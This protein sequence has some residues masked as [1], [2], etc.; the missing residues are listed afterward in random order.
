MFYLLD[1][2]FDILYG[3]LSLF[4]FIVFQ[5]RVSLHYWKLPKGF[6][7][8]NSINAAEAEIFF[9]HNDEYHHTP[10]IRNMQVQ[11]SLKFAIF[12]KFLKFVKIRKKNWRVGVASSGIL[13]WITYNSKLNVGK[14]WNFL[15][16]Y[17][18]IE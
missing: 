3:R 11:N 6:Q 10:I 5:S 12:T 7:V 2:C 1:V 16:V 17:N 18:I 15:C 9:S 14:V 8:F 13:L 4:I